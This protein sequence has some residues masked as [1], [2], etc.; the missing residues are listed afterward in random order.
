[1]QRPGIELYNSGISATLLAPA[2]H[3][4]SSSTAGKPTLPHV[5]MMQLHTFHIILFAACLASASS[6]AIADTGKH[7]VS[8]K[9]LPETAFASG[10]HGQSAHRHHIRKHLR[11]HNHSDTHGSANTS[12]SATDKQHDVGRAGKG[13]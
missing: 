1:M 13:V 4:Q 11:P 8:R 10:D 3:D 5:F 12:E 6:S 9:D 2:H 7:H